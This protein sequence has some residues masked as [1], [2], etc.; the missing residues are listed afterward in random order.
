MRDYWI[1][2]FST[3][4]I[5]TFSTYTKA[6]HYVESRGWTLGACVEIRLTP[7]ASPRQGVERTRFLR[8]IDNP[9]W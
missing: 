1:V 7:M 4:Y 2:W 8:S 6:L 3:Q 5:G 9:E